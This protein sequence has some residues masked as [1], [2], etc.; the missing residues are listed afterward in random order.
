MEREPEK[1]ISLNDLFD[2]IDLYKYASIEGERVEFIINPVKEGNKRVVTIGLIGGF[3]R[4]RDTFV[5]DD[6]E[7]FD[8]TIC[9][10]LLSYFSHDDSLGNWDIVVPEYSEATIKGVNETQS[11]NVV[12]LETYNKEYFDT[13]TKDVEKV[14]EETE[15]KKDELTNIDKIWEEIIQYAKERRVILDFYKGSDFSKEQID[16]IYEFIKNL[17]E[18]SKEVTYGKSKKSRENNERYLNK[19]FEEKQDALDLG[20]TEEIYN[21]VINTTTVKKLS[22]LLTAE[23]RVRNRLDLSNEEINNRIDFATSELDK[24][25]FFN[26]KN[27]SIEQFKDQNF[28]ESKPKAI[29]DLAAL[30]ENPDLYDEEKRDEF[31][32]YCEEILEYLERKSKAGKKVQTASVDVDKKVAIEEDTP[33]VEPYE[34]FEYI[35][36]D[37]LAKDRKDDTYEFVF[38]KDENNGRKVEV[39]IVNGDSKITAFILNFADG[40]KFDQEIV[41][42]INN[43]YAKYPDLKDKVVFIDETKKELKDAQELMR[44]VDGDIVKELKP[45]VDIE[46]KKEETRELTLEE[47]LEKLNQQL[48]AHLKEQEDKKQDKEQHKEEVKENSKPVLL[49]IDFATYELLYN[50]YEGKLEEKFYNGELLD[51]EYRVVQNIYRKKD[52]MLDYYNTHYVN[53]DTLSQ[54]DTKKLASCELYLTKIYEIESKYQDNDKRIEALKSN[55][56][57]LPASFLLLQTLV[58]VKNNK[59]Q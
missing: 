46:V 48:N 28:V 2:L 13:L 33:A 36:T 43:F 52:E 14:E 18:N 23:K 45:E 29:K 56:Y 30:Y 50:K 44:Q 34:S 39:Y 24:V 25:N 17:A 37:L 47:K 15:Y 53:A 3:S 20:L 41:E 54:E 57:M 51:S 22:M 7:E 5:F 6:G 1:N 9:P 49:D 26:L 4:D 11:G 8:R 59:I 12:Y 32:K 16:V 40:E 58:N 21:R 55:E 27:A 35:L 38:Q 10:Q 19:L 42:I 31:T